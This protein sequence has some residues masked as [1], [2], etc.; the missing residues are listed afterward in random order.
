MFVRV[1]SRVINGGQVREVWFVFETNHETMEEMHAEL[2][3]NRSLFGLRIETDKHPTVPD[4]RV[5]KNEYEVI[6][7]MDAITSIQE[8]AGDLYDADGAVLYRHGE[9]AVAA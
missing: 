9:K 2:V 3:S 8:M 1:N 5:L 4:A 7:G 6:L